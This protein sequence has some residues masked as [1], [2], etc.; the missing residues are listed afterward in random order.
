MWRRSHAHMHSHKSTRALSFTISNVCSGCACVLACFVSTSMALILGCVL[1]RILTTTRIKLTATFIEYVRICRTLFSAYDLSPSL[2]V[3]RCS[4]IV[5]DLAT[6]LTTSAATTA[7][8]TVAAVMKE[9]RWNVQA[10][11]DGKF[12]LCEC[13]CISVRYFHSLFTFAN[14]LCKRECKLDLGGKHF[15][16]ELRCRCRSMLVVYGSFILFQCRSALIQ[17]SSA[18]ASRFGSG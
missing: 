1:H 16:L 9:W 8:L 14:Y 10:K 12:P 5:S 17:F 3:I 7:A 18:V 11:N 13:V 15:M 2:P 4:L 6:A